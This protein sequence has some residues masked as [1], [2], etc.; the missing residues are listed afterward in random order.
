M[1]SVLGQGGSPILTL[2]SVYMPAEVYV[3]ALTHP[4]DG[5]MAFEWLVQLVPL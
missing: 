5:L 3:Y 2:A 1:I 4:V